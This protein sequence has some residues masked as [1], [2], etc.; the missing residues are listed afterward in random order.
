MT[1]TFFRQVLAPQVMQHP[2]YKTLSKKN[3]NSAD[4]DTPSTLGLEC[5]VITRNVQSPEMPLQGYVLMWSSTTVASHPQTASIQRSIDLLCPSSA[6]AA[7][8]TPSTISEMDLALMLDI[9]GRLPTTEPEMRAMIEVSYWHQDNNS[10]SDDSSPV[11]LTAFAAQPD[12]IPA[13]QTHFKRYRDAT[14]TLFN[15]TLK[16]HIQAMADP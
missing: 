8:A 6:T 14:R 3:G 13:I 4:T 2:A 11:L 5:R 16:L 12:Q 10:P 15:I 1:Q 9:P 7:T